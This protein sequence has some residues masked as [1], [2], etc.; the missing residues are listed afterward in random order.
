MTASTF[1]FATGIE[2][3]YPT[4][5]NGRTRIDE[6]E[7]CGHYTLWRTDFD[8]LDEVGIH[9]LRYGPPIHTTWLGHGRYDWNFCDQTFGELYRRNVVPIVDL[10]HFGVP[11]WIGNFQNP[12]FPELFAGYAQAFAERFPWVQFYTPVNE[13]FV[14]ATFSA[15]YGWWNEQMQSDQAFVTALKHI[16]KANVLAMGVILDVRADAIF[17][18][19]ESSEH[20][21]PDCP[22]AIPLAEFY[23]ARRFLPLDLNQASASRELWGRGTVR[24]PALCVE[25]NLRH[26]GYLPCVDV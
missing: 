21:H 18:Q 23:N 6:M 20:F 5:N 15:A 24:A 10:C 2:N 1:L 11:D 13:M 14:C 16:V 25:G 4:I 19:S 8:L 3:S 7:K 22:G 26:F 12:D 9:Y 17:I